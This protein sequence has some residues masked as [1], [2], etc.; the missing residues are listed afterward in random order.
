MSL[1]VCRLPNVRNPGTL[2][3]PGTSSTRLLSASN[4]LINAVSLV[5]GS[6]AD[7]AGLGPGMK[8]LG[9]NGRKFDE[10]LLKDAIA[11]TPSSKQVELLLEN[12]T[13]FVNARLEY[14]GGPRSPHLVRAEQ[15]PDILAAVILARVKTGGEK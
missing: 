3:S 7:K 4:T 14:D 10:D 6:P 13:Y 8:L 2:G 9:I 5:P 12:A 1:C 15:S 11:A